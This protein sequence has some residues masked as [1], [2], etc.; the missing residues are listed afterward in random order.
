LF[1]SDVGSTH[2]DPHRSIDAAH[3]HVPEL[4]VAPVPQRRSHAPQF[5]GSL[6]TSAQP[7][8]GHRMAPGPHVHT[9]AAHEPPGPQL[10][11]HMP[12][13]FTSLASTA[14]PVGHATPPAAQP[15][16]PELHVM[17]VRPHAPQF[18][19][20]LAA[21][22]HDAPQAIIG[23]VQCAACASPPDVPPSEG[24]VAPPQPTSAIATAETSHR[25]S[26]RRVRMQILPRWSVGPTTHASRSR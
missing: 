17:Q 4:Q 5:I 16:W 3:T 14:Q 24:R 8:D 22:T 23:A 11:P 9:P 6:A 15:H 25:T 1:G 12:Q 7:P 26:I 20:S 10:R 2:D 19:V 13:L 18:D 21:F